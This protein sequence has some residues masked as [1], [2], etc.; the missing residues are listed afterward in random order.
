MRWATG[1]E[2]KTLEYRSRIERLLEGHIDELK[3][4]NDYGS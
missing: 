1:M 3:M 2:W 4:V